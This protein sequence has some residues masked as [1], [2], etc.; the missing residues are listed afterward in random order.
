MRGARH[1][2]SQLAGVSRSSSVLAVRLV[3]G[4]ANGAMS[5][6]RPIALYQRGWMSSPT[7]AAMGLAVDICA[8]R[9]RPHQS[10]REH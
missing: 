2:W 1:L 10:H 5:T 3:A 9:A 7:A 6:A 8:V 4:G